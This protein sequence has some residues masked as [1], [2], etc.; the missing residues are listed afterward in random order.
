ML[1][2]GFAH[3]TWTGFTLPFFIIFL[4]N[5]KVGSTFLC[6]QELSSIIVVMY[7]ISVLILTVS[8]AEVKSP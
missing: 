1:H 6:F 8:L 5:S 3:S 7:K 2:I 4:N